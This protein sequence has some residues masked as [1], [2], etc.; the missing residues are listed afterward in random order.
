MRHEY[1]D[2]Y[3]KRPSSYTIRAKADY[4][5]YKRPSE[6]HAHLSAEMRRCE[7][8]AVGKAT[9][10]E[11]SHYDQ[12]LHRTEVAEFGRQTAKSAAQSRTG[13]DQKYPQGYGTSDAIQG[14]TIQARD[15]RWSDK[16]C[17]EGEGASSQKLV[18]WGKPNQRQRGGD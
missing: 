14:H 7:N 5:V 12:L 11:D 4:D 18:A 6:G 16:F 10:P 8:T 3:E 17:R 9:Y 2:P 13:F 1:G 15:Q